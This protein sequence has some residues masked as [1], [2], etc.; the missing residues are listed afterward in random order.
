MSKIIV[1]KPFKAVFES[2]ILEKIESTNIL[3]NISSD[4]YYVTMSK[5]NQSGNN[6]FDLNSPMMDAKSALKL[7]RF[8]NFNYPS[9]EIKIEKIKTYKPAAFNQSYFNNK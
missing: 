3:I 7:F 1:E 8:L 9:Y 5:F 6:L 2:D 4:N